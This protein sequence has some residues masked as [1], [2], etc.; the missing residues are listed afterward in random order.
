[1]IRLEPMDDETY[2]AWLMLTIRE[3]AQE[4]VEAGNWLASEAQERS[5]RSFETLLP[6]GRATPGHELRSMVNE[7]GERVG[8]A[9]FVPEDRSFGRVAYIYDIAVDPAHRRKGYARAALAEIEAF[10]RDN[11]CV[12]V[13]LHVFGSNT[14]A[15]QLYRES[16]YVETNL[17]MLKRVDI[18]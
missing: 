18:T 5:E 15:R 4:K 14:G 10:A 16:G 6:E 17:T 1:M 12:G 3:Y 11:S 7:S 13:E 2:Q 9:W 8:Y